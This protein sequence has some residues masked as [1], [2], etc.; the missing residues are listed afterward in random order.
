MLVDKNQRAPQDLSTV[1]LNVEW[2]VSY[3][4][5]RYSV[6]EAELRACVL[7]VGPSAGDVEARLK[8]AGK[9]IFKN[10]GED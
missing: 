3:W 9:K 4:C 1:G 10:M 6:T 2:E 7:E 8:H 5:T